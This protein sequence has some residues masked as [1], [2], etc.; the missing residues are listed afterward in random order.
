MILDKVILMLWPTANP[1]GQ[2]MIAKWYMAN[3][4]TPLRGGGHALRCYQKYVGHD[5][6]ATPTC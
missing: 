1:D 2:D 4:G 6:T 3:V 5:T